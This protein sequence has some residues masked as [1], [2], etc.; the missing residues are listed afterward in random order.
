MSRRR[1]VAQQLPTGV[2]ERRGHQTAERLDRHHLRG[3]IRA[4]EGDPVRGRR[5]LI[6]RQQAADVGP[7]D[8]PGERGQPSLVGLGLRVRLP[9]TRGSGQRL[10]QEG[11]LSGVRMDPALG[12]E[13]LVRGHHGLPVDPELPGQVACRREPV[14]GSEP[15]VQRGR[16][17]SVGDLPVDRGRALVIDLQF[18]QHGWDDWSRPLNK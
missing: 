1:S 8:G 18:F 14:P 12:G 5:G 7:L 16:S 15:S 13:E 9:L 17:H 6:D 2:A 10:Y 4:G 11:A 3:R